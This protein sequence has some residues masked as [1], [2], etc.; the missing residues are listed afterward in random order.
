Q[1]SPPPPPHAAL[2]L[3][4]RPRKLPRDSWCSRLAWHPQR[5]LRTWSAR[6]WSRTIVNSC[7]TQVLRGFRTLRHRK[8]DDGLYAPTH[9]STTPIDW[10]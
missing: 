9:S 2:S 3:A 1:P 8:G 5:Q 4:S 10:F 6:Q 7:V